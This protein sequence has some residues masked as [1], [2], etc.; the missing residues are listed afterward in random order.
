M[1]LAFEINFCFLKRQCLHMLES[2]SNTMKDMQGELSVTSLDGCSFCCPSS[3]RCYQF[4]VCLF[5]DILGKV[6]R[7]LR[8]LKMELLCYPAIPLL[9][10]LGGKK[11]QKKPH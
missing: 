6:W 4:L 7:L 8:K 10:I 1:D 2:I 5:K 11:K 3:N 9:G